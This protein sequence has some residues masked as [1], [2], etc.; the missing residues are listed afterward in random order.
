M[1]TLSRM[2][3]IAALRGNKTCIADNKN[4]YTWN[5]IIQQTESRV[6]FL[7]RSFSAEQLRSVCYLSKNNAELISWLAA[8][9]TLGIPANGLDY[10]LPT[11]TLRKLIK[12]ISPG[13]LLVSFSL[14][15][16]E[17][18]SNLNIAGTSM[19]G[20]NSPI[21]PVIE[22]IGELHHPELS[23]LLSVPNASSFRAVALTSGTSALPKIAL[24]YRSFDA[25]RFAWFT[26]RFGFSDSDG[27]M[28][29]LPLYHAA[30]N[31]WARMF[32]GLVLLCIWSTKTMREP[33]YKHSQERTSGQR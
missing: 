2:N 31:G 19:L 5:D 14:Y 13:L 7:R 3:E 18:L 16:P 28:L 32:M 11:E 8:F 15:E 12:Q 30:G 10:S 26:D 25:R 21:D 17:E 6:I 22:S 20:V 9:A 4:N 1:I 33:L 24:R 29:I 23:S 27:F